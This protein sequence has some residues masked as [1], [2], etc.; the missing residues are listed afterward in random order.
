M[1]KIVNRTL[2]FE[3]ENGIFYY[4]SSKK[5]KDLLLNESYQPL[6]FLESNVQVIDVDDLPIFFTRNKFEE[7]NNSNNYLLEI[8]QVTRFDFVNRKLN[9]KKLEEASSKEV[10]SLTSK[11]L[12]NL[13]NVE[14]LKKNEEN[15][16]LKHIFRFLSQLLTKT[17]SKSTIP[18]LNKVIEKLDFENEELASSL[19]M[20]EDE[21]ITFMKYVEEKIPDFITD[22]TTWYLNNT[23]VH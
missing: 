9:L 17:R 18:E 14:G 4:N 19:E 21:K 23:I 3:I 16:D 2:E 6:F 13:D 7:N 10:A 11:I 12:N 8:Y 5:E 1:K 20:L 22:Y 15:I